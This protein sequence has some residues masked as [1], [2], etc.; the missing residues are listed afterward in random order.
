MKIQHVFQQH[1][2]VMHNVVFPSGVLK[3]LKACLKFSLTCMGLIWLFFLLH[4]S[5]IRQVDSSQVTG[6]YMDS[7][8]EMFMR[9]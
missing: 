3:N 4:I 7:L 2:T 6:S 8:V 5:I 1:C 9:T